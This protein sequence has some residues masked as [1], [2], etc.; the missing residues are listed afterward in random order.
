V[1]L[2]FDG[3]ARLCAWSA[4]AK[5]HLGF[6]PERGAALDTLPLPRAVLDFLARVAQPEGAPDGTPSLLEASVGGRDY[7]LVAHLHDGRLIAEFE[8][9]EISSE[10]LAGFALRAHAGID[11]LR[12]Q[13]GLD[14][15]LRDA[16]E[17]VRELTGFDRVMAYRFRHDDSGDVVAESVRADWSPFLG[18][19]YPA[20]DI[21]AQARRLYVLNTLRL[22][23]DVDATPVPLFGVEGARPPSWLP[24]IT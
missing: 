12:R 21:P 19:R 13:R 9:R 16:V 7:D 6:T 4:N 23:G 24:S 22:I 15:L 10:E 8:H 3:G 1:L 5:Q 14:A 11:R 18:M 17:W 20:S 2:A